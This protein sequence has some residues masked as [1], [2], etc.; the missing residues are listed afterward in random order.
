MYARQQIGA[1]A[2]VENEPTFGRFAEASGVGRDVMSHNG[3]AKSARRR[4][5]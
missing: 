2:A 4:W 3:R 5:R 1:V